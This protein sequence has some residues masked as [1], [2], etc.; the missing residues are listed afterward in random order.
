MKDKNLFDAIARRYSY[1]EGFKKKKV[2]R[3]DLE[4]IVKAGLA[5]PSGKN[6]QTTTF[7]I[8]DDPALVKTIGKMHRMPAMQ[9]AG[10]II[11]CIIDRQPAAVYEGHSFQVEDCSA[12]VENM[13]LAITASGYAGVWIDGWLRLENHA[14]IIG[15]LL[16]VPPNKIVRVI[17]PLGVPAREVPRKPKKPF[18][19]R[20]WFNKYKV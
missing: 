13:L 6:E 18:A 9:T 8:V 19:E 3:K 2:P 20:A 15:D 11:A 14:Q 10:A 17:V 4:K 5:A 12:A 7:V 16:G 1:R